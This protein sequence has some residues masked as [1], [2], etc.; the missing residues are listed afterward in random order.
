VSLIYK[1]KG[2]YV[3]A[4]YMVNNHQHQITLP[5]WLLTLGLF[6]LIA[7]GV[8]VACMQSLEW[9]T[10][11]VVITYQ[12]LLMVVEPPRLLFFLKSNVYDLDLKDIQELT[13]GSQAVGRFLNMG[14]VGANSPTDENKRFHDIVSLPRP[15][16]VYKLLQAAHLRAKARQM[17]WAYDRAIPTYLVGEEQRLGG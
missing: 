16:E 9:L 5:W 7:L 10:F 2:N 15:D 6:I 11:F 12:R 8:I 4:H 14:S 3:P 17:P 1:H 13:T